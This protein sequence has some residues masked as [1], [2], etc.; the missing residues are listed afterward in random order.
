MDN[1]PRFGTKKPPEKLSSD[2]SKA[3]KFQDALRHIEKLL[4]A[5]DASEELASTWTGAVSQTTHQRMGL[6]DLHRLLDAGKR[7]GGAESARGI[8]MW[9]VVSVLACSAP[10]PA[11]R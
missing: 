2:S 6:K 9:M 3:T 8:P 11:C 5:H 10:V 1:G 4:T 7:V